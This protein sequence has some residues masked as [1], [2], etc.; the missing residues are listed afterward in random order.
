MTALPVRP[1]GVGHHGAVTGRVI[2]IGEGVTVAVDEV[3]AGQRPLLLVHG[4]TGGRIDFADHVHALADAGWWVVVPDLRGHGDSAHPQDEGH[5]SLDHFAT[6]VWRLVDALGWERLVLLG[7]SMGGM[8]AQVA[9]LER[10]HALDGLVLM[11]T[12]HGPL[13]IDRE[14]A[15]LGADIVREGGMAAVKEVLD[16][17]GDEGPLTTAAHLRVLAER[18]GYREMGDR[19]FLGCSP[20]MYAAMLGQLLDQDDR[21]EGLAALD[22]PTLVMVGEQDTPFLGPSRAMAEAMPAAELAVIP[23]AG[24]SPQFE[25]P[26]AWRDALLAFLAAR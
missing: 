10:P 19:K 23:D 22:V 18:P 16:A 11:D 20:V 5:Y 8:I 14:L 6:D 12:T 3:G 4:F 25:H 7:H 17:M 1:P 13:D 26:D 21:L 15:A 24:H 9:A 2:D